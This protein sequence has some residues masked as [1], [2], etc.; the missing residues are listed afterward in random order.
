MKEI[1]NDPYL[2]NYKVDLNQLNISYPQLDF[3]RKNQLCVKFQ[4]VNCPF[5]EVDKYD[6]NKYSITCETVP[7]CEID[8]MLLVENSFTYVGEILTKKGTKY[9]INKSTYYSISRKLYRWEKGNF[10]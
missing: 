4:S 9:V 6:I 5:E 7:L 8:K 3:C 10:N 2:N 1:Y